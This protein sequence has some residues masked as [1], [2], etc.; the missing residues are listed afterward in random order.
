MPLAG[1]LATTPYSASGY[2]LITYTDSYY[3]II[4]TSTVWAI[5]TMSPSP[6][7]T[8]STNSS[9][10]S[11]RAE[12]AARSTTQIT[13]SATISGTY[14]R[15]SVVANHT[16]WAECKIE[17]EQGAYMTRGVKCSF[18]KRIDGTRLTAVSVAFGLSA[19]IMLIT[20]VMFWRILK[21]TPTSFFLHIPGFRKADSEPRTGRTQGEGTTPNRTKG[22]DRQHGE[23]KNRG[24]EQA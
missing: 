6:N 9:L 1:K 16:V 4:A 5:T 13:Y 10:T 18:R 24:S 2:S 19:F 14:S 8:H 12:R 7:T 15:P 3:N 23:T 11:S 22:D 21:S 20:V 17:A